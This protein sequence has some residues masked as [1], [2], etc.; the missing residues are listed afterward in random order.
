MPFRGNTTKIIPSVQLD[1]NAEPMIAARILFTGLVWM[2][3]VPGSEAQTS[4]SRSVTLAWREEI[5]LPQDGA[6]AVA[7]LDFEGAARWNGHAALPVLPLQADVPG[8]GRCA[9]TLED[10]VWETWK[11]PV[12][13]ADALEALAA[14]FLIEG[15]VTADRGKYALRATLLPLQ[16]KDGVLQRLVSGRITWSF[17][18]GDGNAGYR[19]GDTE[20]SVLSEGTIHRLAVSGEGVYR[21]TYDFLK[22]TVKF[23]VDQT[24]PRKISLYGNGGAMLPRLNGAP[25]EDD[26]A[27]N[28]IYVHGQEDGIF[29]P[30]DY[31]LFFAHGPNRKVYNPSAGRMTRETHLFDTRSHYFMKAEATDGLRLA[32]QPSLEE[33]GSV[34]VEAYDDVQRLEDETVNLLYQNPATQGSGNR[35]F[36]DRLSAGA[37][38]LNIKNRFDLT[39]LVPGATARVTAAFASR[40]DLTNRFTLKAGGQSFLSGNINATLLGDVEAVYAYIGTVN[41]QFTPPG[42]QFDLEV[43]YPANGT[44][45]TGWV[46]FVELNLRR[47]LELGSKP[48]LFTDIS[49][50]GQAKATYRIAQAGT[51]TLVWDVTDPLRPSAQEAALEGNVLKFTRP[52]LEYRQYVAFDPDGLPAP[53]YLGTVPNQNLH[54]FL[55]ADMAIVFPEALRDAAAKLAAHRV[56]HSGLRVQLATYEEIRNEFASGS[57]DPFAIRDFARM[58]Y[59]RDAAFR[60]LLLLGDASFDTRNNLGRA[61]V[62][63]QL[64]TFETDESLNPVNAFPTDDLFALMDDNEGAQLVGQ[65]LDIAVGRLPAANAKEAM[66]LVDKVIRY[67]TASAGYGDWRLRTVFMADDE[68]NNFHL[69][70]AESLAEETQ[71]WAPDLNLDKIYLD[72]FKQQATPG[73]QRYPDANKAFNNA[74]FKGSLLV[75]YLGHGNTTGWTQERVVY[76]D[77]IQSWTNGHRLP[78]F[79]TA[80]CTFAAFD[81]PDSRSGAELVLQNNLGGGIALFSTVRPVY[82]GLNKDLAGK[83]LQ[84]IFSDSKPWEQPIGEIL[85]RAKNKRG[86]QTND[87]K[88][89]LLGDPAQLL[90]YPRLKVVAT[91]INGRDIS[92]MGGVP[93]DTLQ[94]LQTVTVAG[95]IEDH[96]GNPINDFDGI[97]YPT[98]F[99]KAIQAKTLGNDPRSIPREFRLQKNILYKGAAT[100]KDGSFSFSFTM[101][102]DILFQP[103]FGKFSFY[104]WDQG[105]RDAAGSFENFQIFGIDGQAEFDEEGPVVEV[106]MNGPDWSRGGLTGERPVLYAELSDD[107]GFNISGSSIGHD[108]VAILNEDTRKTFTLNDFFEPVPDD[109]RKAVIRYPLEKLEPGRYTI[110]VRAWDLFNNP[111]EGDTEFVVGTLEDGAVAHVL[112]Y[113]NPVTDQTRFRFEHNLAGQTLRVTIDIHDLQGRLVKTIAEDVYAEQN[114]ISSLSWDGNDRNGSPL[115]SGLYL[116]KV[117]IK[118]LDGQRQ[119]QEAESR[120]EKLVLL[121]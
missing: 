50:I 97:V 109:S 107:S 100:V 40:S 9:I 41:A 91:H 14:A 22:N 47:R 80:T 13:P 112:N 31:I 86:N 85:R 71:G 67:D 117:R 93:A 120:A 106:F 42:D 64:P 26:L 34:I 55:E 4:G 1:A 59:R 23:P 83:A 2:S 46:D 27:E 98:L 99:D 77:D 38:Q 104:A 17:Q 10:A 88:F 35:W 36:G 76:L 37:N 103:G 52:A 101:P 96:E 87:R 53:E 48:L 111:G 108:P 24:D 11:E 49:G 57:N 60:Y 66:D 8:P 84:E 94:A 30:T 6:P 90:A 7:W 75:N 16:L 79:I 81:N 113:P 29:H 54:G 3:L 65:S 89:L 15:G 92:A 102:Q 72:A 32:Q 119:G 70:D 116:Y 51:R 5:L 19:G 28:A 39:G 105:Q 121:K 61:N 78:L 95:R 69:N 44:N 12:L 25:R 20:E 74:V 58:L 118:A 43:A 115:P 63:S 110:R 56:S 82:A 62:G 18:P 68:D 33:T 45:A 114:R 73:G 21:L